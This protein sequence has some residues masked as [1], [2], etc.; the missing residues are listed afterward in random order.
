MFGSRFGNLLRIVLVGVSLACRVEPPRSNPSEFV[1]RWERQ[2]DPE[3]WGDTLDFRADGTVRGVE[4]NPVPASARWYVS[5]NTSGGRTFCVGDD[6]VSSCKSFEMSN[7][8]LTVSG[9][10]NQPSVFRRIR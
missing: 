10:P 6:K 8:I 4:S 7:G 3:T 2:I 1:G 9:G 5:Q